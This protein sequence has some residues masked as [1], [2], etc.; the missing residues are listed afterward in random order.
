MTFSVILM[1]NI[2]LVL[3]ANKN[4]LA[5]TYLVCVFDVILPFINV[6]YKSNVQLVY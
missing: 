5:Y 3:K 4:I 6:L 2:D 1:C